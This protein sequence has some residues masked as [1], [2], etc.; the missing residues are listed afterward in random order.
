VTGVRLRNVKTDAVTD[1][2]CDG[3]FLAIG[4]VPNTTLLQ[5]QLD[6]DAQGYIIT[7]NKSTATS[8]SGVFAAGDVQDSKYRQAITAAGSGCMAAL[9]V[10]RFLEAEEG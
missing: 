7:Q 9:E 4:H 3:F 8:V 2:P 10:E 1:M 5:G 6:L